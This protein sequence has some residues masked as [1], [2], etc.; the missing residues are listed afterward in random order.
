MNVEVLIK[1]IE[2]C[3]FENMKPNLEHLYL[4]KNLMKE[5]RLI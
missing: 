5:G 2:F 4:F 1:Y 3:K